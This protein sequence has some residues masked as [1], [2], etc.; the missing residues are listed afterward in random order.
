[1]LIHRGPRL[2]F[3]RG[4]SSLLA[5][6]LR[7]LKPV[8]SNAFKTAVK[9]ANSPSGQKI[10]RNIV[11]R[12]KRGAINALSGNDS[13]KTSLKNEITN[14]KKDLAEILRQKD[15]ESKAL[16]QRPKPRR[17]RKALLD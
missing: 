14:A 11:K 4:F 7:W 12:V 13:V 1:M 16:K 6:G 9:F 5:S 2:Q 15:I 8:A 10:K 17:H 3:G